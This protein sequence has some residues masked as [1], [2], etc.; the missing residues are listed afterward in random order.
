[1]I[2]IRDVVQQPF[3]LLLEAV[4]LVINHH[5]CYHRK[6][7]ERDQKSSQND[8]KAEPDATFA[9]MKNLQPNIMHAAFARKV[10]AMLNIIG[11]SVLNVSFFYIYR[12]VCVNLFHLILCL[13]FNK[14]SKSLISW[15]YIQKNITLLMKC[16][17]IPNVPKSTDKEKIRKFLK[18]TYK[19]CV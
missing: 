3:F 5:R 9:T 1:M 12:N 2:F 17:K 19:I 13:L 4:R 18:I 6:F 7:L 14:S 10:S 15:Y 8:N 11:M 16:I